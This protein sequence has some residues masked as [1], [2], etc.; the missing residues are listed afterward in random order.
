LIPQISEHCPKKTPSRFIFKYTS[1]K[2]PGH[3]SILIPAAGTAQQCKTS[4]EVTNNLIL[5][6]FGNTRRQSTSNNRK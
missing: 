3:A 2:R 1:F 5:H 6:F 4:V